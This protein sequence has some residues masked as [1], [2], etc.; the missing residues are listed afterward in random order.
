[1]EFKVGPGFT[2]AEWR[3][4]PKVGTKITYKYQELTR[5]PPGL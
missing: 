3:R 4:P 5:D 2:D 1:M